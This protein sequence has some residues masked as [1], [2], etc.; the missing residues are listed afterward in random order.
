[1]IRVLARSRRCEPESL[2]LVDKV[3][4]KD[5]LEDIPRG[6]LTLFERLAVFSQTRLTFEVCLGNG[7]A[8]NRKS[9][10]GTFGGEF[11]G[12]E[13]IQPARRDGVFFKGRSLE[14]F[15]KVL[16][17]GAEFA[18]DGELF[19]RY[20]HMF[21][22]LRTVLAVGKDMTELTVGELM[23]GTTYISV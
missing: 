18:S 6:N 13:G 22:G 14:E 4:G 2:T 3:D 9:G 16:D 1:M 12:D 23:D 8:D 7:T 11:I 17:R 10:I 15:D 19:E 20:D 5:S 21:S